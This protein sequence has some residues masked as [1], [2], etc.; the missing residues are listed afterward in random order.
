[1]VSLA[2]LQMEG[3]LTNFAAFDFSSH[4]TILFSKLS[5]NFLNISNEGFF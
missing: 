4:F 5:G 1:M 3:L 2:L